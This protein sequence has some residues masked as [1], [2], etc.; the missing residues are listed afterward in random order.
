MGAI[1]G[2]ARRL[3]RQ[4]GLGDKWIDVGS[5]LGGIACRLCRFLILLVGVSEHRK[6]LRNG[7]IHRIILD[8]G[9]CSGGLAG[10][11]DIRERLQLK[12]SVT[13]PRV[14]AQIGSVLRLQCGA[15]T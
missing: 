12:T 4:E 13:A 6:R 11:V 9:R 3:E 8:T 5:H 14:K 15:E 1:T 10:S 7:E 2:H